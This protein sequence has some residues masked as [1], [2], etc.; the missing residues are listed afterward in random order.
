[1]KWRRWFLG[2]A[3]LILS[4]WAGLL[5]L[6]VSFP[7]DPADRPVKAFQYKTPLH[8]TFVGTSLTASYNWPRD[9]NECAGRAVSVS[10][11][12]RAGAASDW[13]V[14]Q[15]DA[16]IARRP[17]IVFIEFSVNDADLRQRITLRESARN[18]RQLVRNLRAGL[19]E[20]QIVLMTMSP[21]H[22]LRRLLRPRLPSYYR[23]YSD[24]AKEL[25][26]GLLNLYPRWQAMAKPAREQRDGL[27]PSEAMASQVILSALNSYLEITC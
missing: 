20:V 11:F 9:L 17:D 24:L 3:L 22:G 7:S 4:G 10:R 14:R 21:A 27:H 8:I 6:G 23:L 25:E 18:H 5:Y 15:V 19:P 26:T 13:G 1:M 12:A 2:G 16:I